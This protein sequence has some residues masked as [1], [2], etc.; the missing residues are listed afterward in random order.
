MPCLSLGLCLVFFVVFVFLKIFVCVLFGVMKKNCIK[1]SDS[2]CGDEIIFRLT[3]LSFFGNYGVVF[4]LVRSSDV[5][6]FQDNAGV[7]VNIK[8]ELKGSAITGP[9]AKEAADIWPR[10]GMMEKVLFVFLPGLKE[11]FIASASGTL[12]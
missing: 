11:I 10:I 5:S 8:G 2:C 1:S 7:L 4:D 12:V 6:R 9:V 3:K